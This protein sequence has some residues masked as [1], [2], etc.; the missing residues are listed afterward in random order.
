MSLVI[1]FEAKKELAEHTA[2]KLA[3]VKNHLPGSWAVAQ[4]VKCTYRKAQGPT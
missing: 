4:G 2:T 1:Q 3:I